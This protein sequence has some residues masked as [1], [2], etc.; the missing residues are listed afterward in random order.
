[1]CKLRYFA[2]FRLD[3]A[4]LIILLCSLSVIVGWII[5]AFNAAMRKLRGL[6]NLKKFVIIKDTKIYRA[7]FFCLD[8][9][10]S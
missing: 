10:E 9:K 6:N 1:M 8:L 5:A 2:K 4:A 3:L 7:D